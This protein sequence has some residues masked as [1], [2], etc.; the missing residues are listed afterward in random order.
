MYTICYAI[1]LP[2]VSLPSTLYTV[3]APPHMSDY[4]YTKV[5]ATP[6]Y[7][8][9]SLGLSPVSH[10]RRWESKTKYIKIKNKK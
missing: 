1:A 7:I 8:P 3:P 2:A 6:Q 5:M 4:P 9:L 10:I